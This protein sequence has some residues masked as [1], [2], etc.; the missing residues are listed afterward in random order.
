MSPSTRLKYYY[1]AQK[2]F[3]K[4]TGK[5]AYRQVSPSTTFAEYFERQD[6]AFK[7]SWLGPKRYEAYKSGAKFGDLAKP[8]FGFRATPQALRP[9]PQPQPAQPPQTPAP[10]AL[11]E[12]QP[13]VLPELTREKGQKAR[14]IAQA[15]AIRRQAVEGL[16]EENA[17]AAARR[18]LDELRARL[19]ND[20]SD[21]TTLADFDA[22]IREIGNDAAAQVLGREILLEARRD[23]GVWD[24]ANNWIDFGAR[25]ADRSL[26]GAASGKISLGRVVARLRNFAKQTKEPPQ[27]PKEIRTADDFL[28]ALYRYRVERYGKKEAD[29]R[30]EEG[31]E[32]AALHVRMRDVSA[33]F[34]KYQERFKYWDKRKNRS[35][36]ALTR[37]NSYVPLYNKALAE[38]NDLRRRYK[39]Q[40]KSRQNDDVERFEIFD[41][42][43]GDSPKD[44]P[45]LFA[46]PRTLNGEDIVENFRNHG[47]DGF[48]DVAQSTLALYNKLSR[49][50]NLRAKSPLL[51]VKF[52]KF[53]GNKTNGSFW[54]GGGQFWT[55]EIRLR[56]SFDNDDRA[57]LRA[58]FA[59]EI[60]HWLSVDCFSGGTDALDK[61]S[62]DLGN[63]ANARVD[64][65]TRAEKSRTIPLSRRKRKFWR[66]D[67][68]SATVYSRGAPPKDLTG[69]D[70]APQKTYIDNEIISTAFEGLFDD[71]ETFARTSSEH[72]NLLLRLL[73]GEKP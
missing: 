12:L 48:A 23:I 24:E 52:V 6:D 19:Q 58:T 10:V 17:V 69:P 57:Q 34:K 14:E 2:D 70:P 47:G 29:R 72:F 35:P 71:P 26:L 59:H 1:K 42:L 7:R 46:T 73:R 68:Y 49:R 28:E 13:L 3:E 62:R 63:L 37:R 33:V 30:E 18:T 67:G 8:D 61:I 4:R 65:V 41:L 50:F 25:Q 56:E 43:C 22:A 32:V 60:G 51:S 16:T 11:P 39:E 31:K 36:K 66:F 20:E 27:T 15:I 55:R 40:R 53:K 45:E 54:D 9:S 38:R 21:E 64:N 5:P 44:G